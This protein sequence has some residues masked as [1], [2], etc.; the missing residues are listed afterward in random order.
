MELMQDVNG[1]WIIGE[2][3][4]MYS[5]GK[6]STQT[7]ELSESEKPWDPTTINYQLSQY[8]LLASKRENRRKK[9]RLQN[10]GD[11]ARRGVQKKNMTMR[12]REKEWWEMRERA[13]DRASVGSEGNAWVVEEVHT[14]RFSLQ[15]MQY[16]PTPNNPSWLFTSSILMWLISHPIYLLFRSLCYPFIKYH[17]YFYWRDLFYFFVIIPMNAVRVLPNLDNTV[18]MK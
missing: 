3:K 2:S 18:A 6:R 4:C 10:G 5:S 14:K 12:E 13:R 8:V 1:V 7:N 17:Y 9:G 16:Y 11:M 15:G